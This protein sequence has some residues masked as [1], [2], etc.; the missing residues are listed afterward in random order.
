MTSKS[1]QATQLRH[2]VDIH[3]EMFRN[4][5]IA[6]QHEGSLAILFR[7]GDK[8]K[9]MTIWEAI[10][11]GSPSPTRYFTTSLRPFTIH[12]C[13]YHSHA[14]IV[15][16]LDRGSAV[17]ARILLHT[18]V[19]ASMSAPASSVRLATCSSP[20]DAA[21]S[22]NSFFIIQMHNLKPK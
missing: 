14:T 19:V 15:Y 12:G 11:Q 6:G 1:L 16:T 2:C 9:T 4:I 7:T 8:Y 5:H 17:G 13:K 3:P 22:S 21:H 20:L 18:P 10:T